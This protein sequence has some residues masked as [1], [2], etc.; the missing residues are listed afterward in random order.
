MAM[1]VQNTGRVH[2]EVRRE[3]TMLH[4]LVSPRLPQWL[5]DATKSAELER[6]FL[7]LFDD[8]CFGAK[9]ASDFGQLDCKV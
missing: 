9:G 7:L 1:A 6:P 3:V 2:T 8:V 5:E 4:I